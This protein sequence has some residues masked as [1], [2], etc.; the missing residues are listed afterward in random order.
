M[1]TGLH[2]WSGALG[3]TLLAATFAFTLIVRVRGIST[4][5][6][7]LGDQI[8]DWT[9]ALRPFTDLP[10]VGPATH[11]G[12]YTIGPA[13][14]WIL[15]AIRVV[16]GPWYQNMPHAGGIGQAILQSAADTLLLIAV[17]HRTRSVWLALT[18]VV[19]LATAAYDVCLS[20]LVWNPVM[21]S[22]LAK[23][24]TA[25]VLVDWPRESATRV[26]LT[27]ALA[28]IAVHA[29][30]GAIFVAVSVFAALLI[31]PFV[32]GERGAVKRNVVLIAAVVGMLQL[33]YLAY[34]V[35]TGFRGRAMGAV[36]TSVQRVVT[37]NAPPELRKSIE[38]YVDAF[39][40][41]EVAPWR[42]PAG[43]WVLLICGAVLAF[44][45]RRDP[46]VLTMT[47]LPQ[48]AALVGYSLF[49][50]DLG[51][52]YYLSLMPAAVLTIVLAV[53]PPSSY[54]LAPV[55]GVAL[56]IGALAI[57]PARLRFAAT[58]H[59]LPE[60]GI[61]VE[62][63]RKIASRGQ[64]MRKIVTEFALPKT[65]DPEYVYRILGGRIDRASPWIGVITPAG[66]VVYRKVEG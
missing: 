61:L 29:Y 24:A 37:G 21:G 17:W 22:T 56:L 30:T 66:D 19:V 54:R 52:Y 16:I 2:K 48:M 45:Y 62:A 53:S 40:S 15:W 43:V 8:R 49:L 47:L 44:R 25:L 7:L 12:G 60:Y 46:V 42:V 57:V 1:S 28:W 34:Q 27:A 23:A 11:V 33:P 9:I 51:G 32:R 14:Y 31:D 36:T 64:P 5:F 50:D 39:N 65:S 3:V 59:R 20:A 13:F 38:G 6:W 18:T 41:I 26:A 35:K 4:H 10:L 55:V 63:S 58:M